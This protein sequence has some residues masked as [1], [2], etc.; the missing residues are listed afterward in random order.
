M[1]MPFGK[2]KG[3]E[4]SKLP[5]DYVYWLSCIDLKNPLKDELDTVLKS[6]RYLKYKESES[7]RLSK[8]ALENE[9]ESRID[10]LLLDDYKKDIRFW[11][12]CS[13]NEVMR[14]CREGD[15]D[16]TIDEWKYCFNNRERTPF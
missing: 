11:G 7:K 9:E 16:L 3:I 5:L 15:L 4:L 13:P 12:H 14:R 8:V 1:K 2:F 6:E 10:K